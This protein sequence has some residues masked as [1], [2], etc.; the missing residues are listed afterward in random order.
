[1]VQLDLGTL[2][3]PAVHRYLVTHN[4]LPPSPLTYESA[5]FP[6]PPLT[7]DIEAETRKIVASKARRAKQARNDAK[8]VGRA[9]AGS[10]VPMPTG[11][12]VGGKRRRDGTDDEGVV[13]AAK[14]LS[15]LTA[16]DDAVL[17]L[18]DRLAATAREHWEMTADDAKEGELISSFVYAIRN[19]GGS[20]TAVLADSY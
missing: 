20:L 5:L 14:E 11:S 12:V 15:Y 7:E 6:T 2:P 9:T 1:M 13:V 19:R 18:G 4:L 3:A 10:A 17:V 8:S 16:F